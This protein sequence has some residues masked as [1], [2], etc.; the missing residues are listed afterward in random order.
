M[1]DP[2][3]KAPEAPDATQRELNALAEDLLR[4]GLGEGVDFFITGHRPMVQLSSEYVGLR[5]KD[6]DVFEVTY[7][8]MGRR[9][10]VVATTDLA[11]ARASF[12]EEVVALGLGRGRALDVEGLEL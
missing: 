8:D 1:D 4:R 7:C 2:V 3:P 6:G 12:L 11:V 10:V 9:T 5:R